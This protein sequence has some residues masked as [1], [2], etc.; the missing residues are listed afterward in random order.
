MI[1]LGTAHVEE[2]VYAR[3]AEVYV[4]L[5]ESGPRPIARMAQ[6]LSVS[7]SQAR[8]LVSKARDKGLLSVTGQGRAGG[9]L[10]QKAIELLEAQR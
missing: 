1:G 9:E 2:I 5:V 10:T 8:N 4:A 6:T 3:A 7:T